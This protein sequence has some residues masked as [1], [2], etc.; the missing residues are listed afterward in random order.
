[1]QKRRKAMFRTFKV[2]FI[3]VAVL[4]IAGGAYAFA[5]ANTIAPGGA[6]YSAAV[7]SGYDISNVVYHLNTTD[8]TKLDAVSFNVAPIAPNTAPAVTVKISTNLVDGTH[9]Q[10]FTT[11]TCVVDTGVATCTFKTGGV[12]TPINLEDMKALDTIASSS[13]NPQ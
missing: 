8:P 7:V 10:D 1:M 5:A 13:L 11:S 12:A 9:P 3:A 6:G 2:L 4:I